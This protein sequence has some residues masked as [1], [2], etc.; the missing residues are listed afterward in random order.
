MIAE[1]PREAVEGWL[2]VDMER[3][4]VVKGAQEIF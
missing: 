1:L 3:S 4:E 2:Q